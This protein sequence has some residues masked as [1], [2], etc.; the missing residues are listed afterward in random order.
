MNLARVRCSPRPVFLQAHHPLPSAAMALST[1]V[2]RVMMAM[3]S[4]MTAAAPRV[5]ESGVVMALFR[6]MKIVIWEIIALPVGQGHRLRA[7]RAIPHLL[8]LAEPRA[9]Y[10]AFRMTI[11]IARKRA[12]LLVERFSHLLC[13]R[14]PRPRFPPLLPPP[15]QA[16]SFLHQLQAHSRPHRS[17]VHFFLPLS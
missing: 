15:S 6:R 10:V 12:D 5:R 17:S 7:V 4:T 8:L 13:H 14:F 2:K 11:Q 16:R 3:S 1:P 9:G